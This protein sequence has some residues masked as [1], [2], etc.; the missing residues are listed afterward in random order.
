MRG[1]QACKYN[2]TLIDCVVWNIGDTSDSLMSICRHVTRR[3]DSMAVLGWGR[4]KLVLKADFIDA[5]LS[6]LLI[7]KHHKQQ[8]GTFLALEIR[9]GFPSAVYEKE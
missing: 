4:T 6:Y 7:R 5:K 3:C 2:S 9:L 1:S 8:G